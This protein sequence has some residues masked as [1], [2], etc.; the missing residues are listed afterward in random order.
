MNL[1]ILKVCSAEDGGSKFAFET[2]PLQSGSE[3][4]QK[5][6]VLMSPTEI[7]KRYFFVRLP[8]GFSDEQAFAARRQ[9]CVLLSGRVEIGTPD[10]E[11]IGFGV[12]ETVIL[13]DTVHT[14]PGRCVKVVG[15]EP[16]LILTVQL[17]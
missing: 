12:G 3:Q 7:C 5:E 6:T 17:E 15:D 16:A 4:F 14:V 8:V 11:V 10:G 2:I 13:E 9:L 1:E